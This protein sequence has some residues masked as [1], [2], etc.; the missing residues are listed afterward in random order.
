MNTPESRDNM[1][2]QPPHQRPTVEQIDRE[3]ERLES[4]REIRK[5]IINII[6]NLIVIAAAAVLVTNV[7]LSVLTVNR[8][9]MNPTLKDGD[10]IISL[11]LTGIK[12]GDIIAFHYNNKI[13]L[14]RV[15]AK[16]GDWVDIDEDGTVYVNESALDEPYVTEKGLGE[17]NITLP[18]QVPDGSLFVMGDHRTTSSDSR[19]KE[20][21]PVK[22]EDVAGKVF[23]RI[24]P[25]SN[26]YFF[27]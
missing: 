26:I 2:V 13:L 14:K 16:A 24:W 3:I 20:I 5:I 11:K 18:Y 9:S 25:L 23:L 4:A 8:S 10:I 22:E 21:G 7:L 15:I 6:K 27:G 17:C 12:H 1:P 19:L